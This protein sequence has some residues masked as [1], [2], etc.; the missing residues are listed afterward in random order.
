[1]DYF[2]EGVQASDIR[3][4]DIPDKLR[5]LDEV[6]AWT[7]GTWTLGP[8]DKRRWNGLQNTPNDVRSLAN[9][10]LAFVKT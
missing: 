2:T 8:D 10:L 4:L 6:T 9:L 5:A 7:T 3:G 1:M